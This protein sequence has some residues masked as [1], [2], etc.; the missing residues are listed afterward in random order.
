MLEKRMLFQK[1]KIKKK[2]IDQKYLKRKEDNL[3]N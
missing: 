2:D 3:I 1:K